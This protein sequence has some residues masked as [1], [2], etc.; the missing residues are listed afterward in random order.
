M[1]RVDA[2]EDWKL[3]ERHYMAVCRWVWLWTC[4]RFLGN[5]TRRPLPQI[6]CHPLDGLVWFCFG[7]VPFCLS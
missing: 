6:T 1:R 7:S 5:P 4:V 3:P 2:Q